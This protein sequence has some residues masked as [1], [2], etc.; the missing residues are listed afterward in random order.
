M[1]GAMGDPDA[2]G[3]ATVAAP[4]PARLFVVVVT[5]GGGAVAVGRAITPAGPVAAFAPGIACRGTDRALAAGVGA[6]TS[7]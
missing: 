2:A 1:N 5:I 4:E 3:G 7:C 6:G